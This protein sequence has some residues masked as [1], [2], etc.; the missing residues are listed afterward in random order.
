M[1]GH[2][3]G[4]VPPAACR[5]G[6]R[7]DGRLAPAQVAAGEVSVA[8]STTHAVLD[9]ACF[10]DSA[11]IRTDLRRLSRSLARWHERPAVRDVV[12]R[13]AAALHAA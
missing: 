3:L 7:F 2:G 5:S 9:D 8:C 12:P 13:L 1:L 10:V 6:A 11:T 4:R